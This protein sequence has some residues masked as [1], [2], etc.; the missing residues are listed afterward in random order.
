MVRPSMMYENTRMKSPSLPPTAQT[1]KGIDP[2]LDVR[3][4]EPSRGIHGVMQSRE[5]LFLAALSQYRN[6]DAPLWR[7]PVIP[8]LAVQLGPASL[9]LAQSPMRRQTEMGTLPFG[10]GG[11]R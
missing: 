4:L 11:T 5:D 6:R 10:R 1:E 7:C 8:F 2:H 3:L 9:P